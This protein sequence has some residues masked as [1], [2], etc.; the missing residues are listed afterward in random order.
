MWFDQ[1][2][3]FSCIKFNKLTSENFAARLA[4]SNFVSKYDVA[5]LVKETD[6]HDKLKNL[7]KKVTSNKTKHAEANKK[8]IDLTKH[9]KIF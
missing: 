3:V 2:L 8:I 6:F 4:Q 9:I 5:A 7:D 1:S